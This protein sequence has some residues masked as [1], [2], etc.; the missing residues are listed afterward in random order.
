[1][2]YLLD[3]NVLIDAD[4]DY[5]PIESVPEFWEWLIYMG[6]KG[7]VKI[8]LEVYEEIKEGNKED[9]LTIWVKTASTEDALLLTEQV[10]AILVSR[11]TDEGY[12]PDLTDNEVEAIG[13]DPFL[14]AYAM[15]KIKERCVVTTEVSRPRRLRENRHLPDVCG[16]FG[17]CC[18]NTFKFIKD[19]NFTTNWK[20]N[21]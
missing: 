11:I 17:V 8:P 18:C 16:G 2:L 9:A 19:S 3:A 4:R 6:K 14:I 21:P 15:A 10:D 13:R 12:A 5:Y 7:E 20:T 1:M